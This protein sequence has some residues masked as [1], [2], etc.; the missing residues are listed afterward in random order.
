MWEIMLDVLLA[1]P[2]VLCAALLCWWIQEYGVEHG[3]VK[4]NYIEEEY[5]ME[6]DENDK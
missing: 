2:L 3:L 5:D 1:M 6:D 4:R